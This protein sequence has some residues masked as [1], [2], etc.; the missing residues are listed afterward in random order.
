MHEPSRNA[1]SSFADGVWAR[2]LAAAV[3]A[4]AGAILVYYHRDDLF[5][6]DGVAASG[7]PP[8]VAACLEQRVG[9]IERMRADGVIDETQFAAFK[10]N[11]EAMCWQRFGD[12][13]GPPGPPAGGLLPR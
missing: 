10:A 8:Q 13:G 6:S 2:L 4:V 3:I 9:S 11:A 7:A 12:G 5:G 1:A